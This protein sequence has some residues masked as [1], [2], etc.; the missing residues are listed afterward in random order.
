MEF[1]RTA[2]HRSLVS[3][4]VYILLNV[5]LAAAILIVVRTIESPLPAFA[6][7]LLSKWRIFA[8]RPRYWFAHVQTNLVDIIVSISLV[9]LLYAAGQ[10]MDGQA[11]MAQLGL[12]ALYV[13]WLLVLKPRAKRVYMVAQAGVALLAGVTA[14]YTLS[15]EWPVSL[16]VIMM[17][18]LG[19]A[20]ARHVLAAYSESDL[21]PLSLIWG[22]VMAELGWIAYHWTIAYNIALA[23]GIKLPQVALSAVI[24]SFAAERIYASYAKHGSVRSQDVMLPLLLSGSLLLLLLTLFNAVPIGSI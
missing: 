8:V 10:P 17:W 13:G 11:F 12:T 2:K 18:L 23:E 4:L 3:E 22:F 14:L 20:S 15:Y 19:Y 1:L 7:V 24:I 21:M 9:V 5:G 6:L 16:V